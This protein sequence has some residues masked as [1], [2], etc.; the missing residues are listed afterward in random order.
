[1]SISE[2]FKELHWLLDMIQNIDVGLLVLNR[3]YEIQAWNGFMEN[4]SGLLAE[5]VKGK[6]LFNLFPDLDE[7]WFKAKSEPVFILKNRA[8][9]TWEQHS[10]LFK[11]KN[12]HPITGTA[13]YMYQNITISPLKSITGE[14]DQISILVYD[15][16]NVAVNRL[17]LAEANVNLEKLARIDSLSGLNNRRFWE[18]KLIEEYLRC[19]RTSIES[20]L[21]MIDIDNFKAIND[22]YGHSCG[23][24][25]IREVADLMRNCQRETDISGRYGGEEFAII[26][27]DTTPEQ[28][29]VFAERLR[30][31]VENKKL[32]LNNQQETITI[33]LGISSY[34]NEFKSHISWIESSD[35][36]LYDS[37]ENGRNQSTVAT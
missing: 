20:S 14:T 16:T 5:S 24:M 1:M 28:A 3:N 10:F 23:D 6:V 31:T 32:M 9:T 13:E 17:K 22:T 4:H 8:F 27:P 29:K 33:S 11:F 15:V 35:R 34:R 18:E 25:V 30:S 7:K 21:I 36:A 37:K 26:L 12:Y 2:E 19:K